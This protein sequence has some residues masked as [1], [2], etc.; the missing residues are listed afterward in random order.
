MH[1]SQTKLGSLIES[2]VNVF[3]GLVVAL[4]GQVLIFPIFGI[5]IPFTSNLGIAFFFTI[6]SVGRSYIIRRY[7]NQRLHNV[8]MRLAKRLN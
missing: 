2:L 5:H 6:I 8:S 4:V 7:F 3:T 1:V